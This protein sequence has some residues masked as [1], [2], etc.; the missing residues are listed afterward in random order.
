MHVTETVIIPDC[1]AAGEMTSARLLSVVLSILQWR[2]GR[3]D[4][5]TVEQS[6]SIFTSRPNET[7]AGRAERLA[8]FLKGNTDWAVRGDPASSEPVG[9]LLSSASAH[10]AGDAQDKSLVVV[11]RPSAHGTP[12][13][14]LTAS[15]SYA[16]ILPLDTVAQEIQ[17]LCARWDHVCD[18][19]IARLDLVRQAD[20]DVQDSLN[21]TPHRQFANSSIPAQVLAHAAQDPHRVAVT[22]QEG[23]TT[24]A[25]LDQL[26]GVLANELVGAGVVAGCVVPIV[27]RRGLFHVVAMLAVM[28]IGAAY[29]CFDAENLNNRDL[30]VLSTLASDWVLV[31][32]E[33]GVCDEDSAGA[34]DRVLFRHFASRCLIRGL[35]TNTPSAAPTPPTSATTVPVTGDMLTHVIHTSGSTGI[36]KPVGIRHES[37]LNFS[38]HSDS[39][40]GEHRRV[41][42]HHSS[43]SFDAAT[44]ELWTPLIR[45]DRVVIAPPGRV[46]PRTLGTLMRQHSVTTLFMTIALLQALTTDDVTLID[47][48]IEIFTGGDVIDAT[49]IRAMLEADPRRSVTVAYGPAETTV[50]VTDRRYEKAADVPRKVPL[51][52]PV[53]GTQVQVL[54]PLGRRL[55]PGVPGELCVAG[56]PVSA[57]Y[58]GDKAA[59]SAKFVPCTWSTQELTMY[60]T[61]DIVRRDI[62]GELE[63]LGRVDSQIK[64]SGFRIEPDEVEAVLRRHPGTAGIA[65]AAV[66]DSLG[67]PQLHA[68]ITPREPGLTV[69][70]MQDHARS[71]LPQYMVP[72]RYWAATTIPLNRSGKVD[73]KALA[74]GTFTPLPSRH[75][76][77]D[78]ETSTEHLVGEIWQQVLGCG[79]VARD[80]DF[81][82]IGGTSLAAL[83]VMATIEKTVSAALP[84]GTAFRHRTPRALALAVEAAHEVGPAEAAATERRGDRQ[85][86]SSDQ[87][88]LV[89]M[90]QLF[91]D[92]KPVYHVPLLFELTGDVDAERLCRAVDA[93]VVNETAL[94]RALSAE[95]GTYWTIPV[96]KPPRAALLDLTCE[97]PADAERQAEAIV[98]DVCTRPFAEG[99]ALFRCVV[100]RCHGGRTVLAAVA[101]HVVFDGASRTLFMHRLEA[102]YNGG[103]LQPSRYPF[104]A[105]VDR[106]PSPATEAYWRKVFPGPPPMLEL[107]AK[108]RP[109]ALSGA[110]RAHRFDWS[111]LLPRVEAVADRVGGTVTSVLLASF[112]AVLGRFARQDDVVVATAFSGRHRHETADAI[113]MHMRTLP[114]RMKINATV[115][116]DRFVESARDLLLEAL[117]HSD[118]GLDR[119]VAL[120]GAE[121][122]ISRVPLA[123]TMLVVNEEDDGW[124][125]SVEGVECA[126]VH[127]DMGV[128]GF[129]L[130][131]SFAV[132]DSRLIG[133][134]EYAHEVLSPQLVVALVDAWYVLLGGIHDSPEEPI[135]SLALMSD[136]ER[137]AVVR[138]GTGAPSVL[139]ANTLWDAVARWERETPSAPALRTTDST[140]SYTELMAH[141]R[142]VRAGLL[143]KGVRAGDVVA[144]SLPRGVG[145]IETMLAVAGLSAAYLPL[146]SDSS[147]QR[148]RDLMSSVGSTWLITGGDAPDVNGVQHLS[149]ARLTDVSGT[150]ETGE[151][152]NG[153]EIHDLLCVMTTSGTTGRP[154]AI[155]LSHANLLSFAADP[156]FDSGHEVVVF[157]APHSFDAATY[158]IWV[159]LVRGNT[160]FV[161][162]DQQ[163]DLADY[164]WLVE[165]SGATAL[166]VT[167]GLFRALAQ[168]DPACFAGLKTVVTGGDVVTVESVR[169]VLSACPDLVVLHTYGPTETTTFVTT[170]GI[171]ASTDLSGLKRLP[172]GDPTAGTR[173]HVLDRALKPVPPGCLGEICIAGDGVAVGY[174]SADQTAHGRFVADPVG[175]SGARMYR[176]GDIGYWSAS[177]LKFV[178]RADQQVKIRGY[179]VEP[180]EV[181]HVIRAQPEV[182]DVAVHA[183]DGGER[184][185]YLGA[186]VVPDDGVHL[187]ARALR[188]RLQETLPDYL[189]PSR[190]VVLPALPMTRNGKVDMSVLREPPAAAEAS[191]PSAGRS[192]PEHTKP[193]VVLTCMREV[194]CA[195]ALSEDDNFF[196]FGGS[197]LD[198]MRLA[199]KIRD[200][201]LPCS[202]RDVYRLQTANLL[203]QSC[204]SAL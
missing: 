108:Q 111:D 23:D 3:G 146:P 69:E 49:V 42:V 137:N 147:P 150:P 4:E 161:A 185:K 39:L 26:S 112:T 47:G 139:P 159:P 114:V 36:P 16:S 37:V 41:F 110:G 200:V 55:P 34:S 62:T 104:T 43:M 66:P 61:G 76:G 75:M 93:V 29:S 68:W 70:D 90:Q 172:L 101:H 64:A 89:F 182:A 157:H 180:G 168:T 50:W 8:A 52:I 158:E 116:S 83:R 140:T 188:A 117:E 80:D 124:F 130:A 44:F 20:A 193:G 176:T 107:S 6:E 72:A 31:D 17:E 48:P 160:V 128:S 28:R 169:Q 171:D 97:S 30:E 100:L 14:S 74:A 135:G 164:R 177:G 67:R 22:T 132:S 167:A 136:A 191:V 96:S 59:T 82:T 174:L 121:R 99:E 13:L 131:V 198:A 38:L 27:T 149:L 35:H 57:G 203:A 78:L 77:E 152:T 201:G 95:A 192:A 156:G 91:G 15:R 65:V 162:P 21:R 151:H 73:R 148:L 60:R 56:V 178:G 103:S 165:E 127:I 115:P 11:G 94:T 46:T 87:S 187:T 199:A 40:P 5:F 197:S 186:I 173:I 163:F 92:E 179:R 19:P 196:D 204:Q 9:F 63:F 133:V 24:Y 51:G 58:L 153:P 141:A 113:G 126:P 183:L 25:E 125:R 129:D 105:P 143:R 184:G 170:V 134:A 81:F 145:V 142:S 53:Q 202:V 2:T 194:L 109:E 88:S 86:L 45:G 195:P 166:H 7:L 154:K 189:V 102:A 181:D 10:E 12:V 32:S 120:A 106:E 122:D 175:G 85:P 144:L 54:D 98:K 118:C 33:A 79:D 18:R 138:R 1:V 190:V 71:H 84:P 119:I 123:Q 155:G